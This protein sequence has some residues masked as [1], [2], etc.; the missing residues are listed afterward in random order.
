MT[1]VRS[2]IA[3]VLLYFASGVTSNVASSPEKTWPDTIGGRTCAFTAA[4]LA[5]ALLQPAPTEFVE[6][7]I[8][9]LDR[10]NQPSTDLTQ[11]DFEVRD[12]G[13]RVTIRSFQAVTA[14]GMGV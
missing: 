2:R 7:D 8:I 13:A 10:Q 4:M 9:A 3:F 1:T 6:L 14:R 5:L 11:N 12:G